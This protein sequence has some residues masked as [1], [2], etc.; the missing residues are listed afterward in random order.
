MNGRHTSC[1]KL[2][3]LFLHISIIANYN[4]NNTCCSMRPIKG[5]MM[6]PM[7]SSLM[8]SGTRY[9]HRVFPPPVGILTKTSLPCAIARTASSCPGRND[10]KWKVSLR[11]L[12]NFSWLWH[13]SPGLPLDHAGQLLL[14][15]CRLITDAME[16]NYNMHA[17]AT[18]IIPPKHFPSKTHVHQ[19]ELENESELDR[20]S[21][22]C[23]CIVQVHLHL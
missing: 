4:N 19:A 8:D 7:A 16:Y 9:M 11:T 6:M 21:S 12:S 14:H 2:C 23:T 20:A 10:W 22:I 15:N 5:L 1:T 18:A 3:H 17:A 13:C